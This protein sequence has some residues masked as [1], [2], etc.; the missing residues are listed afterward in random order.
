ML[1]GL[2]IK[3]E[4]ATSSASAS[5]QDEEKPEQVLEEVSFEGIAKYIESEKCKS[6]II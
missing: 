3:I 5:E 2:G 4:D 6:D 1:A